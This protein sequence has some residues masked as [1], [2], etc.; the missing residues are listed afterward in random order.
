MP[1]VADIGERLGRFAAFA[2]ANLTPRLR[3]THRMRTI[4]ASLAIENNTLSEGQVTSVI[5]GRRVLGHPHEI[6]EVRN[7]FIT[8][9]AM[10]AWSSASE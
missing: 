3:R 10:A 9:E 7:A 1:R 5:E 4:H 6:Q 2:Y 8:Y